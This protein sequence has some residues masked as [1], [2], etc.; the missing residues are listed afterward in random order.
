MG[1]GVAVGESVAVGEGVAV[2]ASVAVGEGVAVGLSVAVGEGV[3]VGLSVAVGASVAVGEG[4]RVADGVIIGVE[5]G[6][7]DVSVTDGVVTGGVACPAG[8]GVA[9]WRAAAADVSSSI[10]LR[11]LSCALLEINCPLEASIIR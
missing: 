5:D 8:R 6:G 4:V 10:S 9:V 1:V 7:A 2:G 3:A 11:S